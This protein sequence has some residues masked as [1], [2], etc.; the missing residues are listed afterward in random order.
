M[1]ENQSS[2]FKENG[3]GIFPEEIERCLTISAEFFP[4]EQ[5]SLT[6]NLMSLMQPFLAT[7]SNL[8]AW[9]LS[10]LTSNGYPLEFAF[11][12]TNDG[13]R[14]TLEISPPKS[15]IPKRLTQL[16]SLLQSL[17][18][19]TLDE[20][21]YSQ[22]ATWQQ[23][24]TLKFGAWL[25]VRHI[26]GKV[27]YKIYVELPVESS[28][29]VSAY[30]DQFLTTP[31]LFNRPKIIPKMVGI[32]PATGELEFYFDV[33]QLRPSGLCDLLTP[34]RFEKHDRDL[35]N[36]LQWVYGKM[37][38][39]Q[40]PGPNIGFSYAINPS[41]L[42]SITA[43][44]LYCFC[45]SLFGPSG[46]NTRYNLLRYYSALKID[47]S[48]YAE[49]SAAEKYQLQDKNYHGLFGLSVANGREPIS[50]VGWTP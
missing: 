35:F 6:K 9:H 47:M 48:Y 49:M 50:Y 8:S 45:R 18:V 28:E 36:H 7:P 41:A 15:D 43:F 42:S 12:S 19:I 26:R 38:T 16:R 21:I 27:Q 46:R 11:T 29:L 34:I 24:G 32:Y 30:M 20:A 23:M 40:F 31:L 14:Y 5:T 1:T 10:R 44:S 39:N 25:G 22:L 2:F 37:I 3:A 13:I 4:N 17:Q 33:N